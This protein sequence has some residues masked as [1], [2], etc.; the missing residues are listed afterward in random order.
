MAPGIYE[1]DNSRRDL[2]RLLPGNHGAAGIRVADIYGS[3]SVGR[4]SDHSIPGMIPMCLIEH[5]ARSD[6]VDAASVRSISVKASKEPSASAD[7]PP[8]GVKAAPEF[9]LFHRRSRDGPD[10]WV[11]RGPPLEAGLTL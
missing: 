9:A 1:T 11:T 10:G 8:A 4:T 3:S 7:R 6:F 5:F 2:D